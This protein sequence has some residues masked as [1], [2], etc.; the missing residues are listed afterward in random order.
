MASSRAST[1]TQEKLKSKSSS[2]R[3][4]V[5][6]IPH[7]CNLFFNS[8]TFILTKLGSI[9]LTEIVLKIVVVNNIKLQLHSYF[10]AK[11]FT[12]HKPHFRATFIAR[13]RVTG[14]T[15]LDYYMYLVQ[16]ATCNNEKE[17]IKCQ[18]KVKAL[19]EMSDHSCGV[20]TSCN[21]P[22]I[23]IGFIIKMHNHDLVF[24]AKIVVDVWSI[25]MCL[26]ALRFHSNYKNCSPQT[27]SVLQI[28][29]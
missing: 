25:F 28:K 10:A 18:N 26:Q 24:N 29:I 3:L 23:A 7:T 15:K 2:Q 14:N 5:T 27:S 8:G 20:T 6:L 9:S 19:T 1:E 12:P 16:H 21:P 22:L 4:F 17:E 13:P 11:D